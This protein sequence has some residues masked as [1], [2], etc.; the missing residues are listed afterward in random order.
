MVAN[1]L[2]CCHSITA[3]I[4]QQT[5]AQPG[6]GFGLGPFSRARK[7]RDISVAVFISRAVRKCTKIVIRI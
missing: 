2:E 5:A 4:W 6:N 1:P 3:A 7:V